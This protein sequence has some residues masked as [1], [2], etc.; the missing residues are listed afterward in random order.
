MIRTQFCPLNVI[1]PPPNLKNL[2]TGLIQTTERTSQVFLSAIL[3]RETG[4][5]QPL[6]VGQHWTEPERA[7]HRRM[8][9]ACIHTNTSSASIPDQWCECRN[10]CLINT[11]F[12]NFS[13]SSQEFCEKNMRMDTLWK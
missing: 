5:L 10:K 11:V 7:E 6:F 2:A 1:C 3:T 9:F 13:P 4:L 12:C 8:L